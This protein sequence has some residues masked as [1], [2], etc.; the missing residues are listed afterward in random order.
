MLGED[1]RP[2]SEVVC[3]VTGELPHQHEEKRNDYYD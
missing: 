3:L 1:G 2:L